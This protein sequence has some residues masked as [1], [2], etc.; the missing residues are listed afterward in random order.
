M[1]K[2]RYESASHHIETCSLICS[3]SFLSGVYVMGEGGWGVGGGAFVTFLD[4]AKYH[5]K[6]T[7]SFPY[8][9]NSFRGSLMMNG[10]R[11]SKLL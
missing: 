2:K 7:L 6:G 4:I 3:A 11:M 1:P 10:S 8:D 5:K 9:R